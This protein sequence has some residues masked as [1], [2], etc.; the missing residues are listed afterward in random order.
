L[1]CGEGRRSGGTTIDGVKRESTEVSERFHT[2][3]NV[4]ENLNAIGTNEWVT[5]TWEPPAWNGGAPIT[6]YIVYRGDTPG[7]V[8]YLT[9][10]G[11]V[12]EYTDTGLTNL[13]TYYYQV[14]AVNEAG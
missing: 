5:L 12:L 14:S 10:V 7:T 9:T 3:S 2:I 6:N 8:T 11:N 1:Y 4:P 13:Q